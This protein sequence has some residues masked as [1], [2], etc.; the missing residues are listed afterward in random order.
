LTDNNSNNN[1]TRPDVGDDDGGGGQQILLSPHG[2]YIEELVGIWQTEDGE[3]KT[4][5]T[6]P[7]EAVPRNLRLRGGA[8]HVPLQS[9]F[10]GCE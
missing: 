3:W 6:S 7:E 5:D 10:Y 8:K 4:R 1:N 2:P 9:I